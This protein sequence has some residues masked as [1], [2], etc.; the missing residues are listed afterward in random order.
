MVIIDLTL[1]TPP[2]EMGTGTKHPRP[3]GPVSPVEASP[4][5]ALILAFIGAGEYAYIASVSR[6]WRVYYEAHVK[7]TGADPREGWNTTSMMAIASSATRF[8]MAYEDGFNPNYREFSRTVAIVSPES[9]VALVCE[10]N[11]RLDT[12]ELMRVALTRRDAGFRSWLSRWVADDCELTTATVHPVRWGL[13][14]L[15]NMLV[16]VTLLEDI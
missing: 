8:L 15:Q 16:V 3:E 6:G 10:S 1:D 2:H 14:G 12:K 13:R 11:I 5:L 9:V 7:G 4:M